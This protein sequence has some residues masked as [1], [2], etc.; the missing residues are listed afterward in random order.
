M[1]TK[2]RK[3]RNVRPKAIFGLP[4]AG[5]TL[6]AAGIQAAATITGAGIGA[7]AQAAAASQQADSIQR[8]AEEQAR[9]LE[10]QNENNNRLQEKQVEI[11]KE[12]SNKIADAITTNQMNLQMLA[13]N[14]S[15]KER[16]AEGRIIVKRGGN[17]KKRMRNG[18]YNPTVSLTGGYNMPFEVTD[19]GGVAY[20]GSTPEGYDLYEILGDNHEHKHKTRG[21]KYKSGVGFRFANGGIVEGEGN[22][23]TGQGEYLLVTPDNG[24]F[25]SKHTINGINPAGLINRGVH[26]VDAYN[27]QEAAKGRKT[28]FAKRLRCGGRVK[29]RL[30][31]FIPYRYTT[32][33]DNENITPFLQPD[34]YES[35]IVRSQAI[36]AQNNRPYVPNASQVFV[37]RQNYNVSFNS[38][39]NPSIGAS[40]PDV[41]IMGGGDNASVGGWTMGKDLLKVPQLTNPNTEVPGTVGNGNTSFKSNF[42]NSPNGALAISTA[43]NLAGAITNHI[44]NLMGQHRLSDAYNK[45]ANTMTDAYNSLRQIDANGLLDYSQFRGAMYL[46]AI[47]SAN[48]NVNPQL[49][50]IN[51]SNLRQQRAINNNTLSS[52]ARLNRSAFFENSSQDA[53]SKVYA[54]QAN[55]E[56]DIKQK[57]NQMINQA[58]AANVQSQNE[59]RKSL[60]NLRLELA[61]YNNDIANERIL[62]AANAQSQMGIN[63]ASAKANAYN[64]TS[65]SFANALNTIGNN[66]YGAWQTQ[67]KGD[68]DFRSALAGATVPSQINALLFYGDNAPKDA[69]QAVYNAIPQEDK[70]GYRAM[71][72]N[73]FKWLSNNG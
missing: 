63:T 44:G 58:S 29:A 38:A 56:E 34:L 52:A 68:I 33:Y 27:I 62:G 1:R 49:Q 53:R 17:I 70:Y 22:Q 54:D 28:S 23:S 30:G 51:R 47:R 32:Y 37:P 31:D 14:E 8:Q 9:A 16:A 72:R 43:A 41:N 55:R 13:G 39:F 59:L 2:R 65:Q 26:P 4:E 35:D 25:I 11:Q 67:Y 61:K 45:A 60:A 24:Y 5:A 71:L 66:Y 3:L 7:A 15:A 57:N 18:G 50:D 42:W 12:T 36:A 40:I 69:V 48:V 20:Q 46:P 64:A 73:K 6:A 10:Q 19:G 21:G